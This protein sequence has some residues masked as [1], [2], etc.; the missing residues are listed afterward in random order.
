MV[1]CSVDMVLIISVFPVG[2]RHQNLARVSLFVF[3]LGS[4]PSTLF[5]S[6]CPFL[7]ETFLEFFRLSQ[8]PVMICHGKVHP[9][10]S[11]R[12]KVIIAHLL[13]GASIRLGLREDRYLM[14]PAVSTVLPAS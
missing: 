13:M 1:L 14:V 12:T 6:K 11:V 2:P 8:A 5:I 9:F 4:S 3:S 10:F 7:G